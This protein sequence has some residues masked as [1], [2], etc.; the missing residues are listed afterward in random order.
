MAAMLLMVSNY[1]TP[2]LRD[3]TNDRYFPS[4]R[5]LNISNNTEVVSFTAVIRTMCLTA[6]RTGWYG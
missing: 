4:D 5:K 3:F 2:C 6:D 1:V